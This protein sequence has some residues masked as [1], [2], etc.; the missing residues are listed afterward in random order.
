MS[1]QHKTTT[2]EAKIRECAN[3]GMSARQAAFHLGIC[4]AS[5]TH[6]ADVLGIK[7]AGKAN[8]FD[9]LGDRQMPA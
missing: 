1:K 9:A 6:V 7:F 2:T 3:M 5:L 4:K 8:L